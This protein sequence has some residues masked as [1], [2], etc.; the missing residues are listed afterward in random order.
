MS[1]SKGT[2]FILGDRLKEFVGEDGKL[3]GVVLTSGTELKADVCLAGIGAL[4]ATDFLKDSGLNMTERGEI[5]VDEVCF[6]FSVF[7]YVD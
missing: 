5:V 3:T 4:P 2:K 6:L 7:N 1:E